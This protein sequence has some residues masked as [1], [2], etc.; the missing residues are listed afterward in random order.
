MPEIDAAFF[1][2]HDEAAA[3]IR[4]KPVVSK[5]VFRGLLPELRARAFTVTGIEGANVLQR[6]RD[7]I[8]DYARGQTQDGQARTW[9]DAKA[10]IVK[11]LDDAHFSPKAAERRAT[12]LLRTHAFQ[13]YQAANWRVA[14]ED[15]DTTHLQYLATEDARVRA[16]HLALNGI[17]LPKNDPFWQKHY[18][19]WE[20]GCRCRVRPMNPDMVDDERAEDA[21]RPPDERNVLEGPVAQRLR[22]GQLLRGGQAYNVIPPSESG[23][24][25]DQAYQWHP[26][27]LRLPMDQI[28]DRYDPEVREDFRQWASATDMGNGVS[29]EKWLDLPQRMMEDTSDADNVSSL[30]RRRD[31]G[32]SDDARAVGQSGAQLL[33]EFRSSDLGAPFDQETQGEF[34]AHLSAVVSGRK[35]LYHEQ[36]GEPT[37]SQLADSLRRIVPPGVDVRAEAGH[38]YIYRP[39]IIDRVISQDP[40]SYPGATLADRIHRASVAGDNGILLGY[41]AKSMFAEGSVLVQVFDAQ[42]KTVTSF[43]S[44]PQAAHESGAERAKDFIEFFGRPFHY[45]V[46]GA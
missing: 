11:I 40:N 44:M 17:V 18:P 26:D 21:G 8:A 22:D 31:G 25:P 30:A 46:A 45:R 6:I 43:R 42:G 15:D 4:G 3:L 41:G 14:Q 37:A 33:R 32:S 39:D 16:S 2:P 34:G 24:D 35:P 29:V 36:W 12:L 5:E 1:D 27:N 38:L 13:A 7:E 20:W 28:L 23:Q 10:A 19:P 9:D